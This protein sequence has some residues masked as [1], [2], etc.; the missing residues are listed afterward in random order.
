[1]QQLVTREIT[2]TICDVCDQE[3]SNRSKCSV[4]GKEICHDREANDS[5]WSHSIG[6]IRKHNGSSHPPVA[7]LKI[8]KACG[9]QK[10]DLTIEELFDGMILSGSTELQAPEA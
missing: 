2:V 1:M 8:C 9:G 6:K 10:T 3:T 7:S 4:C 5:H